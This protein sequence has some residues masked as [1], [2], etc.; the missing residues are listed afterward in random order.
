MTIPSCVRHVT[1]NTFGRRGLK[2]GLRNPR[3]H[4]SAAPRKELRMAEKNRIYEKNILR[5]RKDGTQNAA[6]LYNNNNDFLP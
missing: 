3:E 1:K 4:G 2:T 6:A 5:K